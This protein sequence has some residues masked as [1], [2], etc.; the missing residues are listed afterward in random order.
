LQGTGV[1]DHQ[2]RRDRLDAISG[3][4]LGQPRRTCERAVARR[5]R[6]RARSRIRRA[7]LRA[8]AARPHG[9]A[10][11]LSGRRGV[12]GVRCLVLYDRS[13]S[14]GRRRMDGMVTAIHDLFAHMSMVERLSLAA[15]G[16]SAVLLA[17]LERFMPYSKG[18]TFLREG[19]FDDFA[20]YTIAQSYVL[21][22]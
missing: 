4:L 6:Q 12:P 20:L 17:L 18:Q 13:Q 22:I 15:I 3:R 10:D 9:D 11:R 7:L 1:S 5:R 2:R 19:F 16:A 8:H 14:R 21:S